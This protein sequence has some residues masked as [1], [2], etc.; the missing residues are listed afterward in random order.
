MESCHE[1]PERKDRDVRVE[2]SCDNADADECFVEPDE[3]D[4]VLMCWSCPECCFDTCLHGVSRFLPEV[5]D[6]CGGEFEELCC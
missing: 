2:S 5:I 1:E 4:D 6:E 3:V